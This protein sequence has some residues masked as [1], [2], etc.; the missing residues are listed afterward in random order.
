MSELDDV[1]AAFVQLWGRLA[2]LWGITPAAGRLLAGLLA[3]E[4]PADGDT[5]AD[6]LGLSRGAVSMAARELVDWGLAHPE[7]V[8]GS[9][10]VVYRPE[11]DLERAIRSIVQARK[12]K[13]WDPILDQVPGWIERLRRERSPAAAALRARLADVAGVVSLVDSMATSF[14]AGGLLQ[15]FGLRTLLRTARR[16]RGE[17]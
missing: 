5:L 13:E 12:R 2:P 11:T 1:R 6:E 14:L 3:R 16:G 17:A 10:R 9:R 15:R 7:R 8:P 4:E